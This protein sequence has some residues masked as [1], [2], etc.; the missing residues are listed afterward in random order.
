M[1]RQVWLV[2]RAST[3][4]TSQ[5][6][7]MQYS[8]GRQT[9]FD[10]WSPGSLILTTKNDAGQAD[11][12]DLNKRITLTA[13]S[14]NFY[15]YFYVQEVQYNDLGSTGAG[16][17][18]TIVCTDLLGRLG[19]IQVYETDIPSDGTVQQ[20]VDAF[21]SLMPT[22]T[23]ISNTS[24]GNSIAAKDEKY[25]GTGLDRLNLNMTTEQGWLSVTDI[26]IYL[27]GRADLEN[28]L[29]AAMTFARD[30]SGPTQIGYS[31]IQRIGLGSNYINSCTVSPPVAD[32]QNAVNTSQVTTYG[33]Y[34]AQ[35]S[36]VDD[37][38]TQA[39]SFAQWQIYSRTDPDLLSF[40]INISD[41]ANDLTSLFNYIY[42]NNPFV[43]VSYKKPGDA[44]VYTSTQFIQGFTMTVTP[45]ETSAVFNTSP[46]Q[47]VE[48][49]ALDFTLDSGTLGVLNTSVLGW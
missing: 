32:Q 3:D 10:S 24:N 42:L 17:T 43:T 45:M 4:V 33:V 15:Q 39:L 12:Y 49:Y 29:P 30:A 13:V 1:T 26:A 35:F 46:A 18:A 28:L 38:A 44:T 48:F 27:Y 36:T 37:T 25:T 47:Y 5:I 20:I 2:E 14:T 11:N 34:G 21:S 7:S 41:T 6:Q 16:S 22:G 8:T 19:R 23:T 31:N 40:Q 9:Q